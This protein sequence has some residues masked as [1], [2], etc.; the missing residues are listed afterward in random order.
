MYRKEFVLKVIL[1]F[2]FVK[3]FW[4]LYFIIFGFNVVGYIY[5]ISEL[6]CNGVIFKI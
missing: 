3:N 2:I 5:V 6:Y 4:I 1:C